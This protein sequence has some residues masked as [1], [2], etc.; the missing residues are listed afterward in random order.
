MQ[1]WIRLHNGGGGGGVG[2]GSLHILYKA[3]TYSTLNHPV[4]M[5]VDSVWRIYRSG[6][7]STVVI[8]GGG[9]GGPCM[10]CDL[11]ACL[12]S[13][14]TLNQPVAMCVDSVWRLYRSG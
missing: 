6:S 5:Y 12:C 10:S 4:V 13:L 9:G 11:Q 3:V 2:W 7:G 8:V 1:E 14:S